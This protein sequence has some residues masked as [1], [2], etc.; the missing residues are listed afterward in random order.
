MYEIKFFP[1]FL[2]KRALVYMKY[3]TD[4]RVHNYE[5]HPSFY[6]LKQLRIFTVTALSY[7]MTHENKTQLW[8]WERSQNVT[9]IS[10]FVLHE[11]K[12]HCNV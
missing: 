5:D 10:D 11:N 2:K 9:E 12:L 1:H 6:F 3:I 7:L 4:M 8:H